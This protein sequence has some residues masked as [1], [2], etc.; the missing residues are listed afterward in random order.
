MPQQRHSAVPAVY[1]ILKK[2]DEILLQL[3]QGSGYFDDWYGVPA[4]HVEPG[5]LPIAALVREIKEEIGIDIDMEQTHFVHTMYRAAHD[6]TGDRADYFWMTEH[7][8][9]VPL[10]CEP[11]KCKELKWF[12][13]DD[14]PE[15]TIPHVR[16]A[17]EAMCGGVSYSEFDKEHSVPSP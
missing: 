14:L 4:G 16:Q 5:E 12:S 10:V 11:H 7:W 15:N 8:N 17:V 6:V 1:L 13:M 2:G 3:R 9:S